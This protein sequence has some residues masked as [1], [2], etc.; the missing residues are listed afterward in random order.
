MAAGPTAVVSGR[1]QKNGAALGHA[2]PEA[3][4]EIGYRRRSSRAS[5]SSVFSSRYFTMMGV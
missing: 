4:L 1:E 5:D 2:V 3:T